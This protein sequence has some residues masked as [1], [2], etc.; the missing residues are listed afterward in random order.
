MSPFD[1]LKAITETK[2]HLSS[3]DGYEPFLINLGLS[4][5]ADCVMSANMMNQYSH[6]PKESQRL[7]YINNIVSRKR[8]A[9]WIKKQKND[10]LSLVMRYYDYSQ[11][12][13][14][15]ALEILTESDLAEIRNFMGGQ[16]E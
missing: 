3:E 5:Y 14:K 12:K 7:Y 16:G 1:H 8:W 6:L 2:E 4:L 15:E 13:A 11:N 10:D 9:K